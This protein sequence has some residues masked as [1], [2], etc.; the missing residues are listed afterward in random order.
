MAK[1]GALGL[2]RVPAAELE[3]PTGSVAL[4]APDLGSPVLLFVRDAALTG[5]EAYIAAV[6][7]HLA[8]LRD[9]YGRPLLVTERA[10][11]QG[12]LPCVQAGPDVWQE[13]GIGPHPMALIIADRWGVVYHAVATQAMTDLPGPD[14][15]EEWVRFLATQCPECGVIDEPGYGE[16]AP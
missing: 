16:W 3:S 9:W 7:A 2:R 8:D 10:V 14:E 13:I 5:A 6:E 11:R 4:R 15:I 1:A 12:A